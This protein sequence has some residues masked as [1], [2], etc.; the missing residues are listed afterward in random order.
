MVI[1]HRRIGVAVEFR[2]PVDI[3]PRGLVVGVENMGTV[4]VDVDALPLLGVDVA[5][6]VA[7][8]VNDGR[9]QARTSPPPSPAGQRQR[10]TALPPRPDNHT[11]W[12]ILLC[13]FLY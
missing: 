5:C 6:N 8:L 3:L 11:P 4:A 9:S 13:R 1:R 10:R 7:A 2:E 12:I